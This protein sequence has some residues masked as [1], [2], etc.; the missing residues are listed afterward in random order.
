LPVR[1]LG[2]AE[3]GLLQRLSAPDPHRFVIVD[4]EDL[5]ANSHQ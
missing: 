3:S 2:D 4:D 5:A 1:S